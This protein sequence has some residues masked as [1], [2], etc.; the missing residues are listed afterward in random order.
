MTM[1]AASASST[2]KVNV[3]PLTA[4][5]T[6]L[7][8]VRPHTERVEPVRAVQDLRAVLGHRR[9]DLGQ[10]Q[11]RREVITMPGQHACAQLLIGAQDLV[12]AAR[13]VHGRQVDGVAPWPGG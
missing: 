1:P 12:R 9:A 3:I 6:G 4:M 11:G 10:V 13:G 8:P 2:G 7:A 5:T